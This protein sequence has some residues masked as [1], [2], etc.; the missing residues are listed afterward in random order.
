[1]ILGGEG[2]FGGFPVYGISGGHLLSSGMCFPKRVL[3]WG[4]L[5]PN[6]LESG[7]LLWFS[8]RGS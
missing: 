5:V 8:G 2:E 6:G 1:M 3:E 7:L 4:T